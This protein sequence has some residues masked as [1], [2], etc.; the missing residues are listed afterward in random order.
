M[1]E[2]DDFEAFDR[3]AAQRGLT[4]RRFAQWSVGAGLAAAFPAFAGAA[5]APAGRDVEIRTPDGAADAWFVHPESGRHPGVLIWPDIFGLRPAFK[6]MA[7]RL[8]G[9][10]YAVL[11]VNPFYRARRTPAAPPRADQ[12]DP[13]AREELIRLKDT[14]TAQ[15]AQTD[16]RAFVAFL[17]QQPSIDTRR[18]IGTAGYCMG[19]PLVLRT[20]AALPDRIGAGASFHGG[21]LVTEQPDS[22]HRLIPR[23]KKAQFL[24]AIAENDDAKEPAAKDVLR[25]SFGH[26]QI[27]AEIEV[28]RGAQHG[29][30]PTDSRVHHPEQAEKAWS[31]MLELFG[32]ALAA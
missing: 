19:G 11:V 8:A 9:A 17:D 14:L 20:V 6:E 30:C 28:Y 22:P 16:A 18:P 13:P 4:R 26:E 15:T 1:C 29:W 5:D 24:I 23:M 12:V 31:R 25:D 2:H 3:L 21:G 32:K 27:P 7:G 10:G